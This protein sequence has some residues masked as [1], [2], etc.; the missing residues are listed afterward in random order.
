L[1]RKA[2][3]NW[4]E[5]FSQRPGC[6]VKITTEATVKWVEELIQS[7]SVATALGRSHGLL[8]SIMH[9]GLKFRNVCARWVP[10]E[11]KDRK[12]LNKWVCLCNISYGTSMQIK[13]KICLTGLLLGTNHGCITT[14]MNKRVLQ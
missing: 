14:N 10:R 7:D 13:E 12:K 6:P 2:V 4:V 8:Y 11:L 9:D 3:Q 5:K 1:S